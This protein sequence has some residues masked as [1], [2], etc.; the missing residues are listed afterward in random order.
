[1]TQAPRRTQ[2]ENDPGSQGKSKREMC[3]DPKG[4]KEGN[5]PG[6]QRNPRGK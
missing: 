4:T 3:Q 1:M 2:E 5:D 6:Y